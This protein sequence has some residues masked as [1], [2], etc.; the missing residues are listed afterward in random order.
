MLYPRILACNV[1]CSSLERSTPSVCVRYC[2]FLKSLCSD[3]QK[4][5]EQGE[6]LQ[7]LVFVSLVLCSVVLYFIVSLMDPGYVQQDREE[8]VRG[9]PRRR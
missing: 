2:D 8:K 6:L 5:E 9:H 1:L 7:P 4:L 3:L